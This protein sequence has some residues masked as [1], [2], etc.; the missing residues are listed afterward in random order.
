ME[1]TAAL[2]ASVKV[3]VRVTASVPVA[4]S[5]RDGFGGG[6]IVLILCFGVIVLSLGRAT[7]QLIVPDA[8]VPLGM[9]LALFRTDLLE[10]PVV[11][12]N[13]VLNTAVDSILSGVA[14][15]PATRSV[16]A[17]PVTVVWEA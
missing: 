5:T 4:D 6:R 16:V 10:A 17:C 1:L 7:S 14:V 12:K 15:P 2:Q 8:A 9:E 3:K 13:V 11:M